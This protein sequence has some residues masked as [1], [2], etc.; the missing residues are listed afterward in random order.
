[1]T[2]LSVDPSGNLVD[3]SIESEV[4][5]GHYDANTQLISFNDARQPADVLFVSFYTGYVMLNEQGDPCAMAGRWQEAELVFEGEA[6][7]ARPR[8][9]IPPFFTTYHSGF[10][11]VYQGAIIY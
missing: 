10:Y 5:H 1:M 6:R 2:I 7:F 3:S 4:I 11:A 8:L 9:P